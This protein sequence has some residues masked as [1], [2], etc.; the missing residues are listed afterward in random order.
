RDDVARADEVHS[1]RVRCAEG[2]DRGRPRGGGDAGAGAVQ[3][4]GD[5]VGGAV[6][7]AVLVVHRRQRQPVARVVGQRDAHEPGGV[8]H[9]EGD[10][11]RRRVRGG[12]DEVAL[13]LAVGVVDDH[14]RLPG[15]DR[16]QGG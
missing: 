12:E 14:D 16:G 8:A 7:V 6:A 15:G 4:D 2:G 9:G 10:Q 11:R 5:P 3:V 13:V 1:G